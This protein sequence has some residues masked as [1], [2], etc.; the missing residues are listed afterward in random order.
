M[1]A[2]P[3]QNSCVTGVRGEIWKDA[4]ELRGLGALRLGGPLLLVR[5]RPPVEK[6]RQRL[7]GIGGCDAK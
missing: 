7:L 2:S 3:R 4:D 6:E 5:W 1:N